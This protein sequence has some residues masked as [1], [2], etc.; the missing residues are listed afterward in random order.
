MDI[1]SI[2]STGIYRAITSVLH[3]RKYLF[4]P[5]LRA[6]RVTDLTQNIDVK[7]CKAFWSITEEYGTQHGPKFI[8]PTLAVNLEFRIPP[9]DINVESV[10]GEVL[11]IKFP[12]KG[13]ITI[14]FVSLSYL[15]EQCNTRA[16]HICDEPFAVSHPSSAT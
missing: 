14:C 3:S 8:C 6:K 10:N 16:A 2:I 7:F 1:S 11:P 15:R 12:I 9:Y 5:E 13:E 4:N